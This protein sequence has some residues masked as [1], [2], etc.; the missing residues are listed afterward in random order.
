MTKW[1]TIIQYYD[2][3]DDKQSDKVQI[4]KKEI[5]SLFIT[6][7]YDEH[8]ETLKLELNKMNI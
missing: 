1:R 7:K 6:S 8:P 2:K 3:N 5:K 4:S